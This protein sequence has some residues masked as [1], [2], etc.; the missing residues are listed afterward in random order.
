MSKYEETKETR[1]KNIIISKL[2]ESN[3]M[4]AKTLYN[5]FGKERVVHYLIFTKKL[6]NKAFVF[7]E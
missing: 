5:T 4:Y 2:F 6:N 7:L 1:L 3:G